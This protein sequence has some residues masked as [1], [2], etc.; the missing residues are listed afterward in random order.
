MND[1]DNHFL[2]VHSRTDQFKYTS[3]DFHIA[4]VVC[5]LY[6]RKVYQWKFAFETLLP[7]FFLCPKLQIFASSA[8]Y[9]SNHLS[10]CNILRLSLWGR[11][12]AAS[13]AV[14]LH[15]ISQSQSLLANWWMWKRET[16]AQL[17]MDSLEQ[18]MSSLLPLV[19]A[20]VVALCR[21][22]HKSTAL[23]WLLDIKTVE[24]RLFRK[25]H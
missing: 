9:S 20:E 17:E 25:G 7:F 23:V 16:W 14:G 5:M 21:W 15:Y 18:A 19:A 10:V 24:L 2:I 6:W 22:R 3:V 4:S 12:E 1:V 13:Q 11:S 8:C